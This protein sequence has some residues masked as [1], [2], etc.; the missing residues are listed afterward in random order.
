MLIITVFFQIL[1]VRVQPEHNVS[2]FILLL[3]Y[4]IWRDETR[5]HLHVSQSRVS[6]DT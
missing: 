6:H 1:L 2:T 3:S 5:E 4:C